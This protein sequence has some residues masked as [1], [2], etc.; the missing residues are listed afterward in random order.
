MKKS[1][2]AL[3]ILILLSGCG[4]GIS[5]AKQKE[6]DATVGK[7]TEMIVG[8]TWWSKQ[9]N[10]ALKF[11][12]D[13]R[14]EE[15]GK[16]AEP[17]NWYIS[18]GE[19][20]NRNVDLSK[21]SKKFI[22]QYCDYF[23]RWDEQYAGE[24]KKNNWKISF[25]EE[26]DLVLWYEEYERGVDYIHEVPEDA[27]LDP[28]FY[29]N[30][31]NNNWGVWGFDD[32]D[33]KIGSIWIFQ[34]D[35]LGAETVGSFNG[36]LIYPDTF[37]WSFKDDYLYIEWSRSE[38]YI[39]DNGRDIDVYKVEK[40]DNEFYITSYLDRDGKTRQRLVVTDKLDIHSW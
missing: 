12:E 35:G 1:I 27:Y 33:G 25:N 40:G 19:E 22:D 29:G 13:G 38:E 8:P 18:F 26:G 21:L 39:A 34:D 14:V 10:L 30:Y 17:G 2:F 24:P 6:I 15:D 5:K 7:Y 16:F 23:L 28:Y 31:R 9:G 37:T 4:N 36:E 20:N 3:I 11:Y 32:G